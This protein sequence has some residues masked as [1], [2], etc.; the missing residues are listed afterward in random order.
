LLVYLACA[1]AILAGAA[2][3][4][5]WVFHVEPLLSVYPGLPRMV[6]NTA[7]AV[8]AMGASLGLV[9]SSR[10]RLRRVGQAVALVV[11]VFALLT[12]SEYAF[13]WDLG[14]DHVLSREASM[15][16]GVPPGRPGLYTPVDLLALSLGVFLLDVHFGRDVRPAEVLALIAIL[17]SLQVVAGYVYGADSLYVRPGPSAMALLSSLAFLALGLAVLWARPHSGL[18]SVVTSDRLGGRMARRF[19]VTVSALLGLGLLVMFGQ[20]GGLYSKPVAGVLLAMA[21]LAVCLPVLLATSRSLNRVDAQRERYEYE[22]ER[23]RIYFAHAAWGAL[24]ANAAGNLLIINRAFADMYGASLEELAGKSLFSVLAPTR[25]EELRALLLAAT[26]AGRHR[27][28]WRDQV[29]EEDRVLL[30]DVTV[31]QDARGDLLH[32]ALYVDDITAQKQA[33]VEREQL[34]V[35]EHTAHMRVGLLAETSAT[36]ARSLE[37]ETALKRLAHLLVPRLAD[38][39]VIHLID[40]LSRT[41]RVV[42]FAHVDAAKEKIL[43]ERC[44]VSNRRDALPCGHAGGAGGSIFLPEFPRPDEGLARWNQDLARLDGPLG[45]RSLICVPLMARSRVLG[46]M[47]I[48]YSDSNRNYEPRDRDLAEQIAARAAIAIE[49]SRLYHE[50]VTSARARNDILAIVSHDLRNPLT[51]IDLNAHRL[52]LSAACA[53]AQPRGAVE[54][55]RKAVK[56]MATLIDDLLTASANESGSL[57]VDKKSWP[58]AEVVEETLDLIEPLAE[59]RAVK[60]EARVAPFLRVYC[61][62]NRTIQVLT[63][64]VSN[65]VK[66]TPKGKTVQLGAEV[67]GTQ[68]RIG[69]SDPGSG[70]TEQDL[71]HIFDRFW[72]GHVSGTGLGLYIAKCLIEAQGGSIWVKS[73]VGRGTTFFF[74]L[75]VSAP[76]PP[77]DL[78]SVVQGFS[79]R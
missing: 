55:I 26:R 41:S 70:I 1:W 77:I 2:D 29:A 76:E 69:I 60:L 47:T 38:Y 3:L 61:D 32:Y 54:T 18:M 7:V 4:L 5:G 44:D 8:T 51:V 23:W 50:A 40:E 6:P 67:L 36:L 15:I 42:A 62:R 11:L 27:F 22:L 59:S 24:V 31:I 19:L 43:F 13:G 25:T 14:I 53:A 45:T 79:L 66:F 9:Q 35:S 30:V 52:A 63:N 12:L 28:E 73:N 33:E 49:N 37:H 20:Q 39:C 46:A 58:L 68:V 74:T 56:R 17:T 65:A 21:S 16:P 57:V 48:G 72:K 75:P 71:P 10:V 64:L 34:L 78:P